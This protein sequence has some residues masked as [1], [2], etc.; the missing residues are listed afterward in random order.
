[1]FKKILVPL[2]G[3]ETAAAILPF[4]EEIAMNGGPLRRTELSNFA[5]TQADLVAVLTAHSAYDLQWVADHAKLVFDT[6][7]AY[8]GPRRE[9]VIRL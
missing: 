2:D 4:V 6:R 3:S 5:V 9:N 1:M 7:N 8:N